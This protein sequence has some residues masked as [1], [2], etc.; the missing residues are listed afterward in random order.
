MKRI[1]GLGMC[2]ALAGWLCGA[3]CESDDLPDHEPP[4]GRGSLIV[5]NRTVYRL[6]VYL[7]GQNRGSVDDFDTQVYD[8]F[9]GVHRLVL[10]PDEDF[11]DTAAADVD[12]LEGR[13]T[14]VQADTRGP[15]SDELVLSVYLD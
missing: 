3:G 11:P 15:G 5:D 12:I 1:R 2:V 14:V 7:D 4:P 13:R 10:D 9:P 6:D 8:L